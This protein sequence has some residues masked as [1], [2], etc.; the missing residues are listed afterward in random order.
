M[1]SNGPFGFDPDDLDRLARQ[2]GEGIR[3]T[4][5]RIGDIIGDA[6]LE[7]TTHHGPTSTVTYPR[8]RRTTGE[9]GDGVWAIFVVGDDGAATV[10]QIHATELDA[11]RANKSNTDPRRRVRFLPYGIAVGALDDDRDPGS[12]T[13]P[14]PDEYTEPDPEH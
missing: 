1:T 9:T 13:E 3:E 12:D 5:D 14:G 11:L 6:G 4:V 10:E 8:R 2:V 7:W